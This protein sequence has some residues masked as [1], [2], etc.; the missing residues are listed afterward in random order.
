M[1]ASLF[2]VARCAIG[3]LIAVCLV[4]AEPEDLARA[5]R[6]LTGGRARR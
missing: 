2:E 5:L 3:G 1:A 6:R 4:A